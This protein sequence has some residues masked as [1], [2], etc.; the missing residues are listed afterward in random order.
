MLFL[1]LTLHPEGIAFKKS[2]WIERI[3]TEFPGAEIME[4]DN[5]SEVFLYQQIL[6][7]LLQ[8]VEPLIIH[9]DS[10]DS[11]AS[12]GN[13]LR[14]IQDVLQ[15]KLPVLVTIQGNHAGVEKYLRAFT[16]YQVVKTEE[17]AIV[18]LK[19]QITNSK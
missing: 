19:S 6:K 17:E 13:M 4:A 2:A 10:M 18:I 3:Q 9:I 8:S 11:E 12:M 14:F 15:K 7:W 16:E 1:Q 5:Y